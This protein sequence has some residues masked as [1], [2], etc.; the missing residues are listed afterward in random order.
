MYSFVRSVHLAMYSM[1]VVLV[2]FM[3]FL[4]LRAHANLRSDVLAK[5]K[6]RV[7][8]LVF[9]KAL[10]TAETRILHSNK[11]FP[12]EERIGTGQ[13]TNVHGT[14]VGLFCIASRARWVLFFC[15]FFIPYVII[16]D[17]RP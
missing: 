12:S 1:D 11:Y 3:H 4:C 14:Q 7:L 10:A 13:F 17:R 16:L 15:V 9:N 6:E 8:I 5:F 2:D